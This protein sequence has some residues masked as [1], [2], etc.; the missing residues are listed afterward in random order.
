MPI[1]IEP[2]IS[3]YL[4][5]PLNVT[6]KDVEESMKEVRELLKQLEMDDSK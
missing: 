5:R 1:V 4:F 6:E 2:K 3:G